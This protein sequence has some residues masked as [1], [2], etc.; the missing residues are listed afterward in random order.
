MALLSDHA[1]AAIGNRELYLTTRRVVGHLETAL[2]SRAA[3]E[4]AKG[5]LM[6][7]E[8]CDAETAFDILRRASQRENRKLHDVAATV[9]A[10]VGRRRGGPPEA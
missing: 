9:V 6:A 1:G 5:V 4:Q 10:G 8:G 7:R 2:E 3:I